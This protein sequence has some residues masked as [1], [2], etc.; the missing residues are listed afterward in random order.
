MWRGFAIAMVA[1]ALFGCEKP[2]TRSLV[3]RLYEHRLKRC[4]AMVP[5][6]EK[7]RCDPPSG[8]TYL[9]GANALHRVMMDQVKRQFPAHGRCSLH[10]YVYMICEEEV[11][12]GSGESKTRLYRL[13]DAKDGSDSRIMYA[14]SDQ[15]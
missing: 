8:A 2:E 12:R 9:E 6:N 10:G 14:W 11:P 3:E 1:L 15:W 5:T 4:L 7:S 13:D